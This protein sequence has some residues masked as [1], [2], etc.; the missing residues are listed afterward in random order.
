MGAPFTKSG[1]AP[2]NVKLRLPAV[3]RGCDGALHPVDGVRQNGG[4]GSQVELSAMR[5]QLDFKREDLM[6]QKNMQDV[7]KDVHKAAEEAKS[8]LHE[9]RGKL[10][11]RGEELKERLAETK[12]EMNKRIHGE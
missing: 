11:E 12:K 1:A 9:F 6:S 2:L 4:A 10:Q 8:K 7:K 5:A 3:S